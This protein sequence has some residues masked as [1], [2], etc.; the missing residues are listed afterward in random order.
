MRVGRI[1][2]AA[3]SCLRAEEMS[4]PILKEAP[5]AMRGQRGRRRDAAILRERAARSDAGI[6][7]D[8]ESGRD[9]RAVRLSPYKGGRRN[10]RS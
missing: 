7:I 8:G 4:P 5:S 3:R 10:A 6:R 9:R 1:D 2:P